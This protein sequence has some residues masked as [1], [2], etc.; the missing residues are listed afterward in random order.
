MTAPPAEVLDLFAV[1]DA[2]EPLPGGAGSSYRAGDLVLSPGRQA[3]V[4]EWLN[5]VLARLSVRLDEAPRRRRRDLRVALPV[6]ARDGSWVVDGWGATRYEDGATTC[7]DLDVT[8]AAAR[9]LHARLA[10]AVPVRPAGLDH[11]T[12]RWARAERLVFGPAAD[13]AA[14][15]AGTPVAGVV[16]RAEALLDACDLGADQ[17]VHADLA[18]NV[19]LDGY[20]AP[21]VIDVSPAWRPPLWAEAVAVLDSVLRLDAP[22]DELV[23]WSTG[24]RRQAMLRA[25]V[26]RA[27]VDQAEAVYDDVLDVVAST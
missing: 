11:R 10:S 8:L 22:R 1:P 26:W 18:G 15:A 27:L 17:L 20:G 6:P 5:P 24:A 25:V 9:V 4:A 7:R 2:A 21:V 16:R 13:L 23:R 3:Q 14:A 19:L 12:D